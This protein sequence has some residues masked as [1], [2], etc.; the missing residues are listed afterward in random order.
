[1][2]GIRITYYEQSEKSIFGL[3]SAYLLF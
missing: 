1:M 2:I 3:G